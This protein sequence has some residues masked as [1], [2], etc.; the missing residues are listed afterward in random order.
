MN[1]V[2]RILIVEDSPTQALRLELEL[3]RQ[4]WDVA[5]VGSADEALEKLER[6]AP[7]LM[8]VDYYLPGMRGDELCRRVRMNINTRGIPI[9]MLTCNEDENVEVQGLDSGADDFFQKSSDTEI[10]VVRIRAMLERSPGRSSVLRSEE[11]AFRRARILTVDDSE[12]YLF[13]LQSLLGSE[14]YVVECART[15]TEALSRIKNEVFDCVLVD[16]VMPGMD[17]IDVCRNIVALRG[18]LANPLAV[19]MLTGREGKDDLTRALEAGADDFVGKSSDEAV[20]KGRIRALLRRKFYQEENERILK[21]LKDKE[22]EAIRARAEAEAAV[23]RE[24]QERQRQAEEVA[25]ELREAKEE[26]ERSNDELMRFNDELQQFAYL[27]SHDLQ[28]PLRSIT[29]FCHMFEAQYTGQLDEQGRDFIRRI[30]SGAAR[31]KDLIRSILDYSRVSGNELHPCTLIDCGE[32][33]RE[34]IGDL[35]ASIEEA[36]AS[37]TYH[38]LPVV[39]GNRSQVLQLFQNLIG[40]AIKYRS[41]QP[42]RIHISAACCGDGWEFT[43]EDNGIGIAPEHRERIFEIFKRLHDRKTYPGTGIGLAVCRRIAQKHGGRIW[44]QAA[45]VAGSIF[46]FTINRTNEGADHAEF[47]C[48]A[49]TTEDP[50][51]R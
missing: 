51:G 27:A 38:D 17:G 14:G 43:V 1:V 40:N 2:P 49:A 19:L 30:V 25:V 39:R 10:L 7:N 23:A 42:P 12:T 34:V 44:V 18:M 29:S 28:E 31:M 36:D 22:L 48:I 15:G 32:L 47:A 45:P 26:L 20:L 24:A 46:R 35:S 3:S 4:G 5:C 13:H 6:I 9:I 8:V 37:V 11:A 33:V 21:T 50:C 41:E 16:L